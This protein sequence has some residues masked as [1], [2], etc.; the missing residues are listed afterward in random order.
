[1]QLKLLPIGTKFELVRHNTHYWGVVRAHPSV[2]VYIYTP[3]F[4]LPD[5]HLPIG[6]LFHQI[7][8]VLPTYM[9]ILS[10]CDCCLFYLDKFYLVNLSLSSLNT[11]KL[12][13]YPGVAVGTKFEFKQSL[14]CC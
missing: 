12:I 13:H 6:I 7:V 14:Y 10:P 11:G 3:D 2:L 4:D 8:H 1:M 5:F 9:L